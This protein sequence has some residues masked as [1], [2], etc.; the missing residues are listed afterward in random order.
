MLAV[1]DPSG[2]VSIGQMEM[3]KLN[4][5]SLVCGSFFKANG[6]DEV[7]EQVVREVTACLD[8]FADVAHSCAADKPLVGGGAFGVVQRTVINKRDFEQV[9][10]SGNEA[11]ERPP[12]KLPTYR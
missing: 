6:P 11:I 7:Y 10:G 12:T 9:T 2:P 1:N 4:T 3:T 8:E 5:G